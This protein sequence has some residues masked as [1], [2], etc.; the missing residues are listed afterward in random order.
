VVCGQD[1]V[2]VSTRSTA[3]ARSPMLYAFDVLELDGRDLRALPL[4][5]R[6]KQLARLLG[7]RRLG[8]VLSD[9]PTMT[10]PRSS[11]RRT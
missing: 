10:A 5:D 7:G 1:G 6:K 11:G 3:T 2:D 8:L 9:T 4:V